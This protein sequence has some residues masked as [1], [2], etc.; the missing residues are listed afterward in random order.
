MKPQDRHVSPYSAGE[1]VARLLWAVVQGTVFRWSFHTCNWWRVFLLNRFGASVDPTCVI[2]RSVRVECPW[3]LTMGRNSCLGDRVIAYCLGS[4]TIGER[5]SVSQGAHMCAGTHDYDRVDMPLMRPPI[6]IG[7]D[8][9]LAADVF[10]GPD[11]T[12][13][14]GVVLGARGVAVRDLEA[15]TVYAGN[16]ARPVKSR[17]RPSSKDTSGS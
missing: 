5:V 13:G 14:E 15:W 7:D 12:I 8:V 9:W 3:N 16:P 4:V 6:S 17:E 10:V 2:R 1:K 11:V